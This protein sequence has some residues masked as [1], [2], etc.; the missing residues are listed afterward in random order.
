MREYLLHVS[1]SSSL[2][3]LP[4][5]RI[6]YL[7]D[8]AQDN[9]L[10]QKFMAA[11]PLDIVNSYI[12]EQCATKTIVQFDLVSGVQLQ[13][14]YHVCF[15]VVL[16][17]DV[18][19][20]AGKDEMLIRIRNLCRANVPK[21]PEVKKKPTVFMVIDQDT[22]EGLFAGYAFDRAY[23]AW[24]QCAMK[25]NVTLGDSND[26]IICD[27]TATPWVDKSVDLGLMTLQANDSFYSSL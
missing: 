3:S 6:L 7:D 1:P 15:P 13:E 2:M 9:E 20:D 22:M 26:T 21:A 27:N 17:R 10:R 18:R 12:I 8:I 23:E 5:N 24:F 4:I 11:S 25:L 14:T 19:Y 16:G